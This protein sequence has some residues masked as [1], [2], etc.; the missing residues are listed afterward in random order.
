MKD[1]SII[2]VTERGYVYKIVYGMCGFFLWEWDILIK[3]TEK[4]DDWLGLTF[5]QERTIFPFRTMERILRSYAEWKDS[6]NEKY[7]R[8]LDSYRVNIW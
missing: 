2:Y 4:E 8:N 5:G 1:K 6:D 3:V 7:Q